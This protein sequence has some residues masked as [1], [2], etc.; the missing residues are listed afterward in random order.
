MIQKQSGL[1]PAENAKASNI[2]FECF[3]LTLKFTPSVLKKR[4]NFRRDLSE[5]KVMIL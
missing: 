4:C 3:L 5:D 2:G 1:D